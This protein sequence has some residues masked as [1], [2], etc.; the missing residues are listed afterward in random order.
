MS[1]GLAPSALRMPISRTRS[2]T[3]TSI[4]FI[5]PTP[6]TSSAM[7]A[8]SPTMTFMM[9]KIAC[10]LLHDAAEVE[11]LEVVDA[12]VAL[13]SS[14]LAMRFTDVVVLRRRRS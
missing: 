1:R 8:M 5:T 14:A 3:L 7:P 2:E 4:M 12:V 11:D 6:P 10:E 13:T 9:A